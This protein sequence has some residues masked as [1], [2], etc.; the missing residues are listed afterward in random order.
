MSRTINLKRGYNI[1]IMGAAKK[2]I[3]GE[4]NSPIRFGVKPVD[5]PGLTPKLEVKPGD[6]IKAGTPLFHDK[7][8]PEIKFTSP[9]SGAV[10]SVE[11]GER[12]R[13]LRVVIERSGNDYINF[14][15]KDPASLSREKITERLL[16][17]GLWPAVRQ[18][19][20]HVIAKPED[21]P[22]SIFISGFDTS[23]LAPDY[24]FIMENLSAPLF[25]TGISAITKLTDGKVNI[26]LK[27]GAPNPP[28]P[29]N[30]E[31]VEI[32]YFSG[33][34]PAGNV[35][36]HI[37]HLDPVNK[38]EVVWYINLQDVIAIGNLFAEGIY[39]PERLIALTGSEVINPQYYRG[40]SGGSVAPMIRDNI[41]S[42]N[43]RYISGNVLTGTKINAD[44]YLGYY[45][46]QVTV[47]PEGDK[48]EFFGWALPGT[49]KLSFSRTFLSSLF[50]K[51]MLKPD[52]NFHGGERAFVIT[53]QY[54]KVL[55]MDIYPM[56]LLK[57]IKTEDIDLMENLGIY[58]VAEEDFALCE[59]ICPS[60]IEIQSIIR[61]G[62]E[63]MIKEMS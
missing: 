35:G 12:R 50:P 17:S 63:L 10:I 18:R 7:N 54:E 19:P 44:G 62:L 61:N 58:E 34:H 11:R 14:G 1:P 30:V 8:R 49:D 28:L 37:H 6:R 5:F 38:G 46:S 29:A 2:V 59:F 60:K 4:S 20:Y 23:P 36:I 33:P 51:K 25:K 48:Y 57:A 24:N 39:K 52:T 31:A 21:H 53:G 15:K 42:W 41:R 43:L 45:D 13:I 9:V 27:K 26:V 47:I 3:A 40:L 56:Q 55:P 22:K 16:M 32:S